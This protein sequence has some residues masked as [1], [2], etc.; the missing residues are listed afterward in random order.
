VL[1][2]KQINDDNLSRPLSID[3]T[4]VCVVDYEGNA[5]F[6][7]QLLPDAAPITKEL[8]P[9]LSLRHV[10][11]ETPSLPS[12]PPPELTARGLP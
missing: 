3:E 8:D 1:E 9:F 7:N 12:W 10:G 5:Q 2:R 6:Q 11:Y 4:T